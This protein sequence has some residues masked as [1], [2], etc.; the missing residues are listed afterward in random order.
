MQHIKHAVHEVE[1]DDPP[2]VISHAKEAYRENEVNAAIVK[3][4][5]QLLAAVGVL[6]EQGL[7]EIG[8][9]AVERAAAERDERHLDILIMAAQLDKTI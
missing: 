2:A 8:D 5:H 3:A 7:T 6:A 1:S 9:Y 4:K